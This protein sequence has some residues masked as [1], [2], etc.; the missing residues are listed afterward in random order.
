M[1]AQLIRASRE[2]D[3]QSLRS[4]HQ[5]RQYG[6]GTIGSRRRHAWR[7]I[8]IGIDMGAMAALVMPGQGV[9]AR[10]DMGFQIFNRRVRSNAQS[11]APTGA[12]ANQQPLEVTPYCDPAPVWR[13]LAISTN[14]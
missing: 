10:P 2:K 11:P 6:G 4:Q 14:S 3:A 12:T 1:A 9:K 8:G 5:R 13:M 7:I